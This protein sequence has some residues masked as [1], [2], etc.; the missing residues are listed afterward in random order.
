MAI[1]SLACCGVNELSDIRF[2]SPAE[3]LWQHGVQ[4]NPR[5]PG[6]RRSLYNVFTQATRFGYD[7]NDVL[8]PAEDDPSGYGYQ[9]AQF[10]RDNN[11]GEVIDA[12]PG[13]INPNS[14]NFIK[15]WIWVV[16][17]D[18]L[19]TWFL[20][21]AKRRDYKYVAPVPTQPLDVILQQAAVHRGPGV[22]YGVN[23][24]MRQIMEDMLR[25]DGR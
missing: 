9:F 2:N 3:Y 10:I 12:V 11:L 6:I 8:L 23:A 20:D 24:R 4:T 15:M 16:D 18:A 22:V 5:L 25:A 14:Q 7:Q 1:Q 13:G 17:W 19:H 21:E